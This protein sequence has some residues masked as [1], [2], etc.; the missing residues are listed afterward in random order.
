M[1]TAARLASRTIWALEDIIAHCRSAWP[2]LHRARERAERQLD[3]VTLA[4][5]AALAEHL[6]AIDA[7]ARDARQGTYRQHSE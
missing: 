7:L 1:P 4:A 3:P 2:A 5:V 6:A